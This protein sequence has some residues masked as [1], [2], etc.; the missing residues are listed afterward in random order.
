MELFAVFNYWLQSTG[1]WAV[2]G[3]AVKED[4][5]VDTPDVQLKRFDC[6]VLNLCGD[7]I[8]VALT[9]FERTNNEERRITRLM[10]MSENA[11]GY[12]LNLVNA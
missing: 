4:I 5:S 6:S 7:L 9:S 1:S 3:M 10:T 2:S 11:H 8:S 12:S